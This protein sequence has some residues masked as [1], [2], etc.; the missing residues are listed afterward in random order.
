M[1]YS[2]IMNKVKFI[3]ALVLLLGFQLSCYAQKVPKNISTQEVEQ[4]KLD[5][6]DEDVLVYKATTSFKF[7]FDERTEK[8]LVEE[9][10]DESFVNLSDEELEIGGY[11]HYSNFSSI[12][13]V[14]G[15]KAVSESGKMKVNGIFHHDMYYYVY[16]YYHPV[17]N[18]IQSISYTK[19]HYDAR[20]LTSTYFQMHY[21]IKEKVIRFEIP[22]NIDIELVE[23]NF[24]N[25]EINKT[26]K[27]EGEI[28]NITY[29]LKNIDAFPEYS[30]APGRSF[31]YP[32][33]II[34][35]KE[36]K[37]D[38]GSSRII[39][40][41]DTQDQYNWY[42]S[43]VKTAN[44]DNNS[45]EEKVKQLTENKEG[46][47]QKMQALFDWVQ[48][49]INYIAYEDGISG[50][51]PENC[52]DVLYNRYGDCKGMANLLTEMLKMVDIDARM[53]WIGTSSIAY[54]YSIPSLAVDNHAICTAIIDEEFYFLDATEKF[55]GVNEYAERIQGRPALIEDGENYIIKEVP[56]HSYEANLN[57]S[58]MDFNIDDDKIVGS[59]N[60]EYNGESN[61]RLMYA[62]NSI[63]NEY[64][65]KAV[66]HLIISGDNNIHVETLIAENFEEKGETIKLNSQV[67][68]ENKVSQFGDRL[69]VDWDLYK[70]F[71]EFKIDS[72]RTEDYV[73]RRKVFTINE[74]HYK[75]PEGYKLSALPDDYSI[76][77]DEFSFTINF[78]Y[79]KENE[80]LFIRKEIIIP[81]GKI[82]VENFKEW[83]NCIEILNNDYYKNA[84]IY[85]K[86]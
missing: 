22:D 71:G 17:G 81:E 50:F 6:I 41:R 46:K 82:S 35:S 53:T 85:E 62:Y 13:E 44:N 48:D 34:L 20:Y 75:T 19:E 59:I 8:I 27:K 84:L 31:S 43:L 83:N 15:S 24:E 40:M 68:I 16:S 76:E 25:H 29:T 42:K 79:S 4:Y 37:N 56:V 78:D 61:R 72:S 80:S 70:E 12:G 14:K 58:Y 60:T 2:S 36:V 30:N 3:S 7:S 1:Q 73:L 9:Q 18:K 63:Y 64:K 66:N 28:I 52:Q 10:N 67:N 77:N 86:I 26:V 39:V 47:V 23:K 54:D 51:Q 65:D 49:N 32:H 5:N 11:N 38:D 74:V 33:I 69:Y 55:I 45:L 21:P 57:K